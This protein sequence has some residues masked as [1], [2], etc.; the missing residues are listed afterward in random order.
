M[1]SFSQKVFDLV[2]KIPSGKV[3]TYK[4]V[5][6]AAGNFQASRAVGRILNANR[7]GYFSDAKEKIPC[8]RV[9]CSNGEVGGYQF[10]TLEKI[11]LLKEEGVLIRNTKIVE[12]KNYCLISFAAARFKSFVGI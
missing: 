8:H 10:G 11:K 4:A 3:A 5:A 12:L 1:V 2:R 9:V 7:R 6:Q